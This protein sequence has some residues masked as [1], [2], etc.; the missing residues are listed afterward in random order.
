MAGKFKYIGTN[1]RI[2]G[3]GQAAYAKEKAIYDK[4]LATVRSYYEK[5][6]PYLEHLRELTPNDAKRWASPLQGD[7]SFVLT[8]DNLFSV[9]QYC[10]Q[11]CKKGVLCFAFD[12]PSKQNFSVGYC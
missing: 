9:S 1:R 12:I 4:E 5:A 3:K 10:S 2:E 7:C 8:V 6:L 11:P